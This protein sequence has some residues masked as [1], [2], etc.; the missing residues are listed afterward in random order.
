MMARP[1]D[2]PTKAE[3]KAKKDG[4]KTKFNLPNAILNQAFDENDDE[5]TMEVSANRLIVWLKGRPKR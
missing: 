3:K 1:T 5:L 2:K 4:V